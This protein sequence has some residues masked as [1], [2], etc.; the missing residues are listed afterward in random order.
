MKDIYPKVVT[1]LTEALNVEPGEVKPSSTLKDDL[2]AE[3]IDV[4]DMV[5][6]LEREFNIKI[7]TDE[8]FPRGAAAFNAFTVQDIV[9][10]IDKVKHDSSVP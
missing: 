10:Y 2:G 6:R 8:M 7:T 1:I 3:S 5:F 9:Q 4:L